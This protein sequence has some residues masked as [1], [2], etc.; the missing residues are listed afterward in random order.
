M[1]YRSSEVLAGKSG[2]SFA[3]KL[4]KLEGRA[5]LIFCFLQQSC[6]VIGFDIRP[7]QPDLTMVNL[8][9][10]YRELAERVKWVHGDLS[11]DISAG[12]YAS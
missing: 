1:G 7:V 6:H 4:I 11:V 9:I 8:G 3:P 5:H 12:Q 10:E 2:L